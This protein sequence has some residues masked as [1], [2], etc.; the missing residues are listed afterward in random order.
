MLYKLAFQKRKTFKKVF[1]F[2]YNSF[3]VMIKGEKL[4]NNSEKISNNIG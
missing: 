2:C 4:G 1:P 3:S